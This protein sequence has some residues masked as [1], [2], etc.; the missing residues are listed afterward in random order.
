[1]IRLR[2]RR[3]SLALAGAICLAAAALV[4][5]SMP[6]SAEDGPLLVRGDYLGAEPTLMI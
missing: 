5:V 1:M 4:A 3:R 6:T 2:V